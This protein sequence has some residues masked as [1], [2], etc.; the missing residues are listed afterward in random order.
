MKEGRIAHYGIAIDQA[1]A[2]FMGLEDFPNAE[3]LENVARLDE[4]LI[5]VLKGDVHNAG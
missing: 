2:D 5:L 1:L 3:R 4:D